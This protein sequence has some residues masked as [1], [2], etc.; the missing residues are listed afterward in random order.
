MSLMFYLS[1]IWRDLNNFPSLEEVHS[2]LLTKAFDTTFFFLREMLFKTIAQG[3]A[4]LTFKLSSDQFFLAGLLFIKSLQRMCLQ[5]WIPRQL[6]QGSELP[7]S[8]TAIGFTVGVKFL[9]YFF[10]KFSIKLCPSIPTLAFSLSPYIL[11]IWMI[12]KDHVT[13]HFMQWNFY[14]T[15]NE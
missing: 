15:G 1:S 3:N 9:L 7:A 8:F 2:G 10:L 11:H 6:G 12:S 5:I 13:F 14:A 4:N